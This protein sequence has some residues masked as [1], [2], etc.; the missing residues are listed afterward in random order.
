M[1]TFYYHNFLS[2]NVSR[3]I[4]VLIIFFAII[5]LVGYLLVRIRT[6]SKKINIG[7]LIVML[8]A[9]SITALVWILNVPNAQ[10]SDFGNFWTRAPGF[11]DGYKLYETD[12]D[13][14]SKYAYQSGFMVYIIGIVKVFG[15]NIFVVQFLNVVYQALTL[16]MTYLLANKIFNNIK[17]ARLSVLLLMVDIDWFALNSQAD[18]QYLGSLLYL[19]TFY[20]L[21]ND[22]LW[23]Y[24]LAGVSLTLAC[25]IRPIGPVFI[26]GIIVFVLIFIL[27]K[28]RDYK[29]GLS[30]LLTLAIYFV[31][32][33]LSGWG[34]KAAGINDYGLSNNDPQWKFL[35]GLNYQSG[36]T[37]SNDLN[38][39]IDASKSRSH[40]KKIENT[41][42]KS[43]ITYLNENN[44][45]LKLFINKTQTLWSSRTLAT[46]FTDYAKKH[47]PKTVDWINYIAY[48][49]SIVLIV[50]SWIGS[51][52]LFKS[53]FDDK[54]YLLLLPLMAFAVIN[55]IIEVQPRY[56]IEFLP[57]ISILAGLGLNN[58]FLAIKNIKK[59]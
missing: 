43:E 55:L 58:V 40:M 13:Y 35:S 29:T 50:F 27:M 6:D 16:L 54:F 4:P 19:V 56:R 34:I 20:L 3:N 53:K 42:L 21:F 38:K 59:A 8:L 1:L 10:I 44:A 31:L 5:L 52:A 32:F 49:G 28:H 47:S 41:Q 12:N 57:I 2:Q 39:F 25:L 7:L 37:Y 9:F 36:G 23:S 45:W 51:L 26:A 22:K 46:D 30:F 24:V 14:F 11:L 17:I 18:N 15:F 33:S 48:M